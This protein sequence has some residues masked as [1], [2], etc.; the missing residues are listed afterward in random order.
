MTAVKYSQNNL[1]IFLFLILFTTCQERQGNYEDEGNVVPIYKCLDLDNEKIFARDYFDKLKVVRLLTDSSSLIQSIFDVQVFDNYIFLN[2]DAKTLKVFTLDGEFV[3]STRRGKGPKEL[4]GLSSFTINTI[5]KTVLLV[6]DVSFKI[7][8]FDFYGN[9]ISTFIPPKK[10]TSIAFIENGSYAFYTPARF[11][12]PGEPYACI[13]ITDTL[14]NIID[15]RKNRRSNALINGPF[16]NYESFVPLLK[17]PGIIPFLSDTL[18]STSG[19]RLNSEY[20][21]DFGNAKLSEKAFHSLKNRRR[22][23]DKAIDIVNI[24]ETSEN[25]FFSYRYGKISYYVVY[26]KQQRTFLLSQSTRKHWKE[27][28]PGGFIIGNEKEDELYYWPKF[29]YGDWLVSVLT[30]RDVEKVLALKSSLIENESIR[31]ALVKNNDDRPVLLFGRL[32]E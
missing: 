30:P 11:N 31:S 10:A 21:F 24:Y 20:I 3:F 4:M 9:H 18:F 13:F 19:G 29:N 1:Y 26:H 15:I 12:D 5:K 27:E 6:D 23:T 28:Q 2:D 7:Q 14:G 22:M 8:E 25:L 32:K 16:V 17:G